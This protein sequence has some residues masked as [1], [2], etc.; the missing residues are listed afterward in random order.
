MAPSGMLAQT[1]THTRALSAK[2]PPRG[3]P[4]DASVPLAVPYAECSWSMHVMD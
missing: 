2:A 4:L 3:V 1:E